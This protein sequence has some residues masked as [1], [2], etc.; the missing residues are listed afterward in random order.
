M[1]RSEQ[2][3]RQFLDGIVKRIFWTEN[4]DIM[5]EISLQF[6]PNA[7]MDNRSSLIW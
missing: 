6:I 4:V 5:N 1:S 3:R 2:K 7:S